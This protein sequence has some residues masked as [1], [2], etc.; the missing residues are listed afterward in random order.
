MAFNTNFYAA[1]QPVRIDA[2]LGTTQSGETTGFFINSTGLQF[3]SSQGDNFGGWLGKCPS[4]CFGPPFCG[5][6]LTFVSVQLVA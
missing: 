3:G 4:L 5:S 6:S 2:G 1:W